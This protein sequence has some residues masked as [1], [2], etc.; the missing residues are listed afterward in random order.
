MIESYDNEVYFAL[1]L[2][3]LLATINQDVVNRPG[4]Y[5]FQLIGSTGRGYGQDL[6]YV[7]QLLNNKLP[8]KIGCVLNNFALKFPIFSCLRVSIWNS[9]GTARQFTPSTKHPLPE[10]KSP[11]RFESWSIDKT[12]DDVAWSDL[13]D[14]PVDGSLVVFSNLR[15]SGF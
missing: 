14:I 4:D 8:G 11:K 1:L 12:F 2:G 9:R 15:P 10:I 3:P 6:T 5:G 13:V 7:R